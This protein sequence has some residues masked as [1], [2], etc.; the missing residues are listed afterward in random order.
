MPLIRLQ[1]QTGVFKSVFALDDSAIF[2]VYSHSFGVFYAGDSLAQCRGYGSARASSIHWP[3]CRNHR[4]NIVIAFSGRGFD[5]V[6]P[7][8]NEQSN[9]VSQPIF[10]D[11]ELNLLNL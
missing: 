3:T 10:I 2:S 4:P 7:L 6:A 8:L 5:L 9:V 11:R 1:P